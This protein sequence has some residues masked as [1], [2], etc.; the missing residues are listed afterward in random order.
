MKAKSA[1]SILFFGAAL[2]LSAATSNRVSIP[3]T[4][5]TLAVDAEIED[6]G[7]ALAELEDESRD[8]LEDAREYSFET[9]SG[10]FGTVMEFVP[11]KKYRD[12][13]K[14]WT[15][16]IADG[17]VEA[18]KDGGE[19]QSRSVGKFGGWD[20]QFVSVQLAQDLLKVKTEF[21]VVNGKEEILILALT[22]DAT[23][24]EASKG[25]AEVLSSLSY[26]GNPLSGKKPFKND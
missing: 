23:D 7:Q 8:L 24:E 15:G 3:G 17:I 1:L 18:V 16:H 25:V 20:A 26:D 2:C 9:D 21:V 6:H 10:V 14:E 13:A 12:A 5:L 19:I 11:K 22:A 4:Q